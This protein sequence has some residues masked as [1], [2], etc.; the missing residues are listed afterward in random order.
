M[1]QPLKKSVNAPR[2]RH[3]EDNVK[4]G[5][6]KKY[7]TSQLEKDFAAEFLDKLGLTYVYQY[8]AKQ[9]GR[10]YDFAITVYD[11][12]EYLTEIKDSIKCVK[13]EGQQFIPSLLIEIDGDYYHSNPKFYKKGGLNR[14]Q[15]R[16][17]AVDKIKDEWAAAHCIPLLRIWESDIKDNPKYVT[18]QIL[19]YAS[20]GRSKKKKK[21]NRKIPH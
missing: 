9:I 6:L 2:S 18:A 5:K 14:M 19:Q 16:N 12:R 13:Q 21:D 3:G 20:E 1:R 11:T 15:R 4:S 8:E 17:K 7:G 10:F